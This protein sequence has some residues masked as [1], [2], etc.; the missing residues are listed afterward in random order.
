[1]LFVLFVLHCTVH[2][3]EYIHLKRQ[4]TTYNN[5]VL[6]TASGAQL[7]HYTG[8]L[9]VPLLLRKIYW[10]AGICSAVLFPLKITRRLQE[11]QMTKQ[12]LK[13]SSRADLLELLLEEHRE[14]GRL[15]IELKNLNEKLDDKSI[16][17]EKDGSIAEA[18]LQ[19]NGVFQ[20]SRR[21]CCTIFGKYPEA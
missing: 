11:V 12:E 8:S 10:A 15:Q 5:Y 20:G 9:T 13:K 1:M 16:Q 4:F 3:I 6:V 19:L 7:K 2:K 17:I 21:R 18:A 14:N